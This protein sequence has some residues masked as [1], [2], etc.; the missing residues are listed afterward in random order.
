[1]LIH[2]K[3]LLVGG[4]LLV[5]GVLVVGF[6]LLTLSDPCGQTVQNRVP[7]PDGRLQVVV[8][9]FGCGAT[10]RNLLYVAIRPGDKR[11]VRR[12][13]A[14]IEIE[15]TAHTAGSCSPGELVGCADLGRI[16]VRWLGN[17]TLVAQ[18]H[19]AAAIRLRQHPS[20]PV[21]VLSQVLDSLPL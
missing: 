19:R 1:M 11:S 9:E 15:D 16:G 4:T 7:S 6:L 17:D 12:T 3:R 5:L 10:T 20:V 2:P 18:Y 14:I 13:D 21:T 8:V